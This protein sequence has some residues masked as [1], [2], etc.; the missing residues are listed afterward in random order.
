MHNQIQQL[1]EH[2]FK[3]LGRV[4]GT[5]WDEDSLDRLFAQDDDERLRELEKEE[6]LPS[7][8][9]PKVKSRDIVLPLSIILQPNLTDALKKG[10]SSRHGI[11]A[12]GW[13]VDASKEGALTD[14]FKWKPEEFVKFVHS[15]VV[16]IAPRAD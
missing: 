11:N 10:Y 2:Q 6:G 9:G 14:V 13:A 5:Y 4:L 1:E 15:V 12:P 16:P 8:L 7:W 3:R